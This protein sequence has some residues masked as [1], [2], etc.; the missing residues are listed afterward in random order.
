MQMQ[1][2]EEYCPLL[3]TYLK[4]EE[5][6]CD[7]WG[8]KHP[9][10]F[11]Y[12]ELSDKGLDKGEVKDEIQY[13]PLKEL[14][15]IP[16]DVPDIS[17]VLSQIQSVRDELKEKLKKNYVKKIQKC[18]P[19]D[20]VVLHKKVKPSMLCNYL[21][22]YKSIISDKYD[23]SRYIV[24]HKLNKWNL[25]YEVHLY[26]ILDKNKIKRDILHKFNKYTA[27]AK[28]GT[29]LPVFRHTSKEVLNGIH[30]LIEKWFNSTENVGS[31]RN[32][33]SKNNF[34][35]I[36]VSNRNYNVLVHNNFIY[37]VITDQA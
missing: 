20:H 3:Q 36:S 26:N 28:Y 21:E 19:Y 27:K 9:P 30:P 24:W 2:Q 17:L 33:N 11:V 18:G 32:Y 12:K 4:G 7:N 25:R 22:C 13:I 10:H 16:V 31:N 5:C 29:R 37:I 15:E 1:P 35:S 8:C 14:K 23:E 6:E 34:E